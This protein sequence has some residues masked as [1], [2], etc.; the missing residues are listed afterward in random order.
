MKEEELGS[1]FKEKFDGFKATPPADGWEKLRDMEVIKNYN[2]RKKFRLESKA[3]KILFW[4]IGLPLILTIIIVRVT[5]NKN[6]QSPQYVDY[7]TVTDTVQP[8]T[9]PADTLQ[10]IS[11]TTT[12]SE[13]LT[14]KPAIDAPTLPSLPNLQPKPSLPERIIAHIPQLIDYQAVKGDKP[15]EQEK[16]VLPRPI[17]G[18][19]ITSPAHITRAL[20]STYGDAPAAQLRFSRDTTI[21]RNSKLEL[22]VENSLKTHWHVGFTTDK[23]EVIPSESAVYYVDAVTPSGADTT[24]AIRV[25]VVDCHLFIPRAFTPNADGL[26]DEFRVETTD[27]ITNFEMSIFQPTGRLL[28]H[29]KSSAQGW[30][31]TYNGEPSAHG[32]YLYVITYK[33][34]LGEKHYEKGQII[35]IR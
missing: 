12:F 25:Q 15:E 3:N 31:G 26:N 2:R 27:D 18:E 20:L 32:A 16:P 8:D 24:I 29:A 9:L 30:D 17:V 14:D 10:P 19:E 11:D 1:F 28:F 13:N 22:F 34:A 35:L 5:I 7:Q 33:D 23:I 4:Y 21:C 6:T